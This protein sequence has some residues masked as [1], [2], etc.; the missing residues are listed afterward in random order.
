[1]KGQVFKFTGYAKCANA[2]TTLTWQFDRLWSFHSMISLPTWNW[3]NP[4]VGSLLT[5]VMAIEP[6]EIRKIISENN[7]AVI[8]FARETY[9][10]HYD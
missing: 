3:E 6:D 7:V 9:G 4:R 2:I 5:T 1:M 8:E 10:R